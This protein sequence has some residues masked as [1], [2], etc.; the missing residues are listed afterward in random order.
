MAQFSTIEV[1][2][3]MRFADVH[4]MTCAFEFAYHFQG[5]L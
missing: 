3:V 4:A 1:L 2:L 5:V